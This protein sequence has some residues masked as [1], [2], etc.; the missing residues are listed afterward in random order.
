MNFDRQIA[1]LEDALRRLRIDFDRFMAGAL[2]IP[3]EDQRFQIERKIRQLRQQKVRSFAQRFRLGTLEASFNTLSELHGRKLRDIERGKVPHPRLMESRQEP[4]PFQGFVVE[5]T[6]NRSAVESL[7]KE[8]YGNSGR[9]RK[10]DFGSF[11]KHLARQIAKLK[12]KTGCAK[13]HL[14]VANDGDTLKLKAKPVKKA[15]V[16]ADSS[17]G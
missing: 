3:P 5:G 7:Y 14:R 15:G 12:K 13:V 16:R 11:E 2:A 9:K 8:L 1:L 10:T 17:K 6:A 4:N